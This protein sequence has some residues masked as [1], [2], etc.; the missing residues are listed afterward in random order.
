M[1]IALYCVSWL[2]DLYMHVRGWDEESVCLCYL[3]S[4]HGF[5]GARCMHGALCRLCL[6]RWPMELIHADRGEGEDTKRKVVSAVSLKLMERRRLYYIICIKLYASICTKLRVLTH[7]IA[8]GHLCAAIHI[9]LQLC[10]ACELR[11]AIQ[12]IRTRRQLLYE[13]IVS[14]PAVSPWYSQWRRGK[15]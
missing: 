14:S 15:L 12:Y 6:P 1:H 9:T 10:V 5:Y 2:W 7:A 13:L 8:T 11:T 3:V 4:V